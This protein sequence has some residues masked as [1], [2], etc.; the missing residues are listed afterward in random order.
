M[1]SLT[2]GPKNQ[3]GKGRQL[4]MSSHLGTQQEPGEIQRR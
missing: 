1:K 4:T 2:T 3:P